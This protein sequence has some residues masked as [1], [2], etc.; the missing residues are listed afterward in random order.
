MDQRDE[1]V[2]YK[3]REAQLEK[4]P[5]MVSLGQKEEEAGTVSVRDRDSQRTSQMSLD[6][7]IELIQKEAVY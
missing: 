1:K 3:I 6:E 7:F 4:V 2:G 5:Y